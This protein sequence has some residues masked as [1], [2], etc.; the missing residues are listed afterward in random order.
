MDSWVA[1]GDLYARTGEA[2]R[3][4]QAYQKVTELDPD[5][6]HQVFFNLGALMISSRDRT[7]ADT[8]KAIQAFREAVRIKPD[9]AEAYKQLAFALLNTGD[10]TAAKQSL[11]HYIK[12]APGAPDAAR[13]Q[14]LISSLQE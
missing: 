7:Q 1:L 12:Y 13:M 2:E 11:E 6:A 14:Q 3:S 9:Y 5:N 8:H 4:E 10:R